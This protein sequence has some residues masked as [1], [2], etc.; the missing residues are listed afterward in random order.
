MQYLG[1]ENLLRHRERDSPSSISRIT[2]GT[3][4]RFGIAD[5]SR[6]PPAATAD[7]SESSRTDRA[8]SCAPRRE[9]ASG[10]KTP[11]RRR[12]CGPAAPSACPPSPHTREPTSPDLPARL[13]AERCHSP[14]SPHPSE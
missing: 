13:S 14:L 5:L 12:R 8:R 9:P 11:R 4:D 10:T 1:Q 7:S 2:Y 3:E 6:L